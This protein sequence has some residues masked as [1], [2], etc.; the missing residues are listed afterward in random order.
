MSALRG[1]TDPAERHDT[2]LLIIGGVTVLVAS[3]AHLADELFEPD[4]LE[5]LRDEPKGGELLDYLDEQFTTVLE[6][7]RDGI[8]RV[9]LVRQQLELGAV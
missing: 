9:D 7:A 4:E 5:A 1:I 2:S 6:W 3:V 8:E